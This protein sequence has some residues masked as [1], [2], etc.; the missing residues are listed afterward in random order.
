M[1]GT[2]LVLPRKDDC[3]APSPGRLGTGLRV[4]ETR[5]WAG[6]YPGCL[7]LLGVGHAF[8]HVSELLHLGW[9]MS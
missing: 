3:G 4:L 1:Q 2:R 7:L 5:H 9:V 6:L 8:Q